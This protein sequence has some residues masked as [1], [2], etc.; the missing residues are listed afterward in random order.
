MDP[1]LSKY[2][3][4]AA[5]NIRVA[6]AYHLLK[7]DDVVTRMHALGFTYWHRQTVGQVERG[8]RRLYVEELYG[9]AQALETSVA[10][11]LGV[12]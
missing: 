4:T 5:T 10:G 6:R 7:Q 9:L 1:A 11:L 2:R 3:E 8:K 12:R